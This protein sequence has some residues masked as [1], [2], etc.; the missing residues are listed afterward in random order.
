VVGWLDEVEEA[1]RALGRQL[2]DAEET[3]SATWSRVEWSERH[4]RRARIELAR[5]ALGV[6]FL[7]ELLETVRT[8]DPDALRTPEWLGLREW[9]EGES[10]RSLLS[11][12]RDPSLARIEPAPERLRGREAPARLRVAE[13]ALLQRTRS[14]VPVLEEPENPLNVSAVLRTAESLGLQEIHLVHPEGV[15]LPVRSITKTCERWL[16]LH[17]WRDGSTA[18]A[19]LRER[20]I[21]IWAAD[22]GPG[23]VPLSELPLETPLALLFGTEQR[24]V[25]AEARADADGLFHVPTAGFA[26]YLNLSVTAAIALYET[27]RRLR[28]EGKRD[29]LDGSERAALRR[30][31]Y[32]SLAGSAAR[33]AE[34]LAWAD[35]PPD[36]APPVKPVPSREKARAGEDDGI[37]GGAPAPEDQSRIPP[38]DQTRPDRSSS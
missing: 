36:P 23:S 28:E 21:R 20:G 13:R 16:D 27:D 19:A 22:F 34:Y 15:V 6:P 3:A 26:S 8:A 25:S 9:P 29:P 33:R 14:L 37:S 38:P 18:R 31:W 2:A 32:P 4:A 12:T 10:T 24:G 5:R 30:A 7:R 11:A 1:M 35:C 17:W